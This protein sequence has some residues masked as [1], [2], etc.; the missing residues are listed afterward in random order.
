MRLTLDFDV[1]VGAPEGILAIPVEMGAELFRQEELKFAARC[2]DEV[3]NEDGGLRKRLNH[4]SND[5]FIGGYGE[6]ARLDANAELS[7]VVPKTS[8]TECPGPR[9]FSITRLCLLSSDAF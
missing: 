5:I 7:S 3:L 1:D 4:G 9:R 8:L 2:V 6:A